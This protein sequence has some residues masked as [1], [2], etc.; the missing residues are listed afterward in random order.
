MR[1]STHPDRE[2]S[3]GIEVLHAALDAGVDLL[4]TAD[5]YGFD[6]SEIGH[7][8]RLIARALA[9]WTGDR[10]RV[11][12]ATKGGLT[13]PEGR[14]VPDG[15]ARHL[16]AACEA[17]RLALGVERIWLY[18]LHA[19]DPRT[20]L[21]TSVRALAALQRE[22]R[23]ESIGLCNVNVGQIEAARG[24]VE[25]ASV[26]VE[27]G[28]WN[29]GSM[30]SGVVG[31]CLA[32][33][34]QVMAYRPLGGPQ[35]ARRASADPLLAEMAA[36]HGAT[37][38]EIAL[39]WL[40]GLS[41]LI[42]PIPGPT[43]VETARSIARVRGIALTDEDR[44]RLDER[45]PVGRIR[46]R[47][48]PSAPRAPLDTGS[49]IVLVMGLPAAGK[50]TVAA[51]LV[52]KGYDRLNR[53]ESGGSL[54]GLLPAFDRLI[55][56]GSSRIVIDNT[57]VTRRSRAAVI[58]AAEAR[59]RAVRCVWVATSLE[60]AQVNA[61]SRMVSRYGRLLTPEEMKQAV[62]LDVSAF[63]PS[64]PF[65]Y[66]REFE[67][68]DRSEGFSAI[69]T[70]AF[71]RRIDPSFTARAVVVWCEGILRRSR[72]GRPSPSSADDVE[73]LVERAA[74]LRRYRDEGW[75]LLG[76]S[77]QPGLAEGTIDREAV[78][79]EF[80]R[81]REILG[82]DIEV[83]DLPARRRTC[84]L[85][86]PQAAA[87]AGRRAGRAPSPRPDALRVRR[88]WTAGPRLCEASRLPVPRCLDVLRGV[89]TR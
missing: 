11:C 89:W 77:W 19:P 3:R 82:V 63:G 26:Q 23:I 39:A 29:D 30:L 32:H 7:N 85:L 15:R 12:V 81:M 25:I 9:T 65:R 34:I 51:A 2:E 18:Q 8:E 67:P 73:V 87:R 88:Q 70:L 52:A 35:R 14:W 40:S 54:A 37:A 50:S 48:S 59:G 83:E 1:L 84:Q 44:A 74:T 10:S 46:R 31:Y 53:D 5:A 62:R 24:I 41:N 22:G 45:F 47:E 79:A 28:V 38:C 49:D 66:Q 69:E 64:V 76:L 55:D 80:A 21:A 17:S 27:L 58:A 42:V 72:S 78:D 36:H 71:E 20:P 13:R 68:P 75:R 6:A 56:S 61:V 60:D 57:Y 86:V 43:R 16:A 4:D 33:G